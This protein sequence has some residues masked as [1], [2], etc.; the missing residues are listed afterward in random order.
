MRGINHVLG[1][2]FCHDEHN[3]NNKLVHIG[4]EIRGIRE[5]QIVDFYTVKCVGSFHCKKQNNN[6]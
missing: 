1:T 4:K 6:Q 5:Q 2:K 3:I